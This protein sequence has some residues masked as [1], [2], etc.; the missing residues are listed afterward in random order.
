MTVPAALTAITLLAAGVDPAPAPDSEDPPAAAPDS[1]DPPPSRSEAPAP[2]GSYGAA[3]GG[4]MLG[5]LP[6][7]VFFVANADTDVDHLS[8]FGVIASLVGIV[9][10]PPIGAVVGWQLSKPDPPGYALVARPRLPRPAHRP[11]PPGTLTFSL[12]SGS[13]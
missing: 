8:Y 3:F 9:V 2:S 12:L 7:V 4:A 6:S 1:E 11:A 13:F 5:L 10:G